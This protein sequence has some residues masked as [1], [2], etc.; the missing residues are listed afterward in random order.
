MIS[1]MRITFMLLVLYNLLF[2]F[3][4]GFFQRTAYTLAGKVGPS[5]CIFQAVNSFIENF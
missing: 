4:G 1:R 5:K 2:G 3:I